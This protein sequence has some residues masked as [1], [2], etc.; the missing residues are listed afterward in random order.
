MWFIYVLLSI[1]CIFVLWH[2]CSKKFLNPYKLIFVFGRKGSGKSTI[3]SKLAYKYLI[4]G[5][6]VYAN[7]TINIKYKNKE[8]STILIDP[9]NIQSYKF[10]EKSIVLLDEVNTYWDNRQYKS[11]NPNTVMWFR[12][13]RHYKVR[14]YLFSQTFD[15][16]KKL[17][18]LCD[19]M[20]MVTKFA[21]LWAIARHMI[22]KPVIVHASSEAPARIDD[23]IIE[24]GLLL[25]PF[26][27]CIIAFIPHWAKVFDSFKKPDEST[28]DISAEFKG[29]DILPVV[30]K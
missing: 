17:R 1:F 20:Y 16:D 6:T 4:Q 3:M 9:L 13:Q 10:D 25:A 8:Y 15:I 12:Y 26:G 19:D 29:S 22:R 14:V 18:D 7:E 24:D 27:G 28:S 21:R 11:M 5:K 23:D 2:I 30:G